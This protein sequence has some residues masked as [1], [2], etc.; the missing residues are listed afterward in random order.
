MKILNFGSCNIDYVYTVDHI[1][2]PGETEAADRL[3]VFPG[4]KGLNQSIAIARAGGDVCHAGC[5]GSDGE[6]LLNVLRDSGVD[7][8]HLKTLD[9]KGGHAII[10]VNAKGENSIFLYAGSNSMITVD[11]VDS[12]L[13]SFDSDSIILLQN[14]INNIGYIIDEA[15]KKGMTVV[16]NP[17]PYNEKLSGIDLNKISY[18]I[19]N[20]VEAAEISGAAD[21]EGTLMYFRNNFPELKV[22]L[23]LGSRGSMYAD[24]ESEHF[25]PIFEAEAVDTTAAG[26]TFTGYFIAE[27]ARG[28]DYGGAMRTA[29]CAAAIAVSRNGAAPSI[30]TMDEV[31]LAL[32][33]MKEKKSG[34]EELLYQKIDSYISNNL[35][36]ATLKN[37][38]EYL[39]Y[40]DV[41]TGGIVKRLFGEAFTKVLQCRRCEA[42][43]E[44]LT[45]TDKPL[46]EVIKAVG[47]E[48]ENFFR[49]VFK[50]KYGKNLLEY[51]KSTRGKIMNNE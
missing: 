45:S 44:L 7:T 43:A 15:Y 25:Q 5:I 41:Y 27:I 30:P 46:S 51:R 24:G 6:M 40:S 28:E 49:T 16:L 36:A 34:K 33:R 39:G 14:E 13:E 17:S 42:A 10:Q 8:A 37:L 23:T 2:K 38:S 19:L 48:N 18:I 47:Y 21:P 3:E 20:E 32:T 12:V 11:F 29:S 4:G 22:I 9:V 26:D 50:E 31:R 35:A 1:V